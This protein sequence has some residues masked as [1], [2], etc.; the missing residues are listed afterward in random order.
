MTRQTGSNGWARW[1]IVAWLA[2]ALWPG[3]SSG[4]TLQDDSAKIFRPESPVPK[5]K[6]T[7]SEENRKLLNQDPRKYVR[8]TIEIDGQRYE[9]VA[10]HLKGAAGSFRNW[11]DRPAMTLNF[12]KFVS[13]QAWYALDKLHLN[14]SVQDGAY[15]NEIIGSELAA[16]LNLPTARA[17]HA[18]VELFDQPRGRRKMGL[19]VLKE[20]YNKAFLK[21]HFP[22]HAEGTLLD[23][24]FLQDIDGNLK[25][26][27]GPEA[28]SDLKRL[29]EACREG[30]RNRRFE[31][32]RPL[33]DL[34]RIV[35]NIALQ[36]IC[37]DWDGYVRNRN[38]YRLYFRSGDRLAIFLPHGMDQLFGNTSDSLRPGTGGMVARA[39][40]ESDEGWKL[41]Q[42]KLREVTENHFRPEWY[43]ARIDLWTKHLVDTVRGTSNENLAKE[44]ENNAKNYKNRLRERSEY[45]KRELPKL[46]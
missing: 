38:N 23:G 45:L 43:E 10:L 32:V 17:A 26:D 7:L 18:L 41:V 42:A 24:G 3:T 13:G 20:G 34:E 5:F 16:K 40:L 15:L 8:A 6:I 36:T 35:A 28:K 30:D 37:C 11:D 19:Y 21:R 33:V 27:A 44:F 12:D 25:V 39:I 4:Q 9:D 14:N 1:A 46:R 29:I 2:L 31:R 22:D